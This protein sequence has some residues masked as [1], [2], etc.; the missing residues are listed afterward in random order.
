M[1]LVILESYPVNPGDLSWEGLQKFGDLQVYESTP[2]DD[3]G[4]VIARIGDA[5]LVYTNKVPITRAILEACPRIRFI[6]VLATGY[7]V[8][9]CQA[10]RE[11]NIPVC[12]VPA[13][14]TASVAQFTMA[15]LLELCHHVGHHNESVHQG[16]WE[17]GPHWCYW[18]YPLMELAGK[19][20]G[21]IGFGRIGQA[22]GRSL[23][24]WGCG[25]WLPAAV[26][27]SRGEPS[28]NMWIWIPC[29]SSPMW[30]AFTALCSRKTGR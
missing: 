16:N 24:P 14:G 19:T 17:K 18:D 6:G 13:Y 20:M 5:E 7:N 15:L 25:F 2:L 11:R 4:E 12:N 22:A 27:Q 1:K 8:V 3:E 10:A 23:P 28:E 9:D 30:S 29:C 26:P 21:I